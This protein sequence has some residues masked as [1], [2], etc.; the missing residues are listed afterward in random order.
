LTEHKPAITAT[1]YLWMRELKEVLK[2]ADEIDV[3]VESYEEIVGNH[4]L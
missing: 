1:L 2:M 3:E 4:L